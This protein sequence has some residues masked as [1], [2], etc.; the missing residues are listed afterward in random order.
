MS[1]AE[2]TPRRPWSLLL[3]FAVCLLLFF[4]LRR[5][6]FD[7]VAPAPSSASGTTGPSGPSSSVELAA[8]GTVESGSTSSSSLPAASSPTPLPQLATS[9]PA[10]L[11]ATDASVRADGGEPDPVALGIEGVASLRA[12]M[13]ALEARLR[14]AGV[15]PE[16]ARSLRRT[17]INAEG[18]VRARQLENG[19]PAWISK[20]EEYRNAR[21]AIAGDAGLD[22]AG[23]RAALASLRERLFGDPP[24]AR[25]EASEAL[26][27]LL[28]SSPESGTNN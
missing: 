6:V 25:F 28:G 22:E 1:N 21:D 18:S 15:A 11:D 7:R 8:Q 5:S 13:D 2:R 9:E 20:V 19:D 14:D 23:R 16:L 4:A 27:R 17:M 10:P 12:R 24:G 3:F 26:D